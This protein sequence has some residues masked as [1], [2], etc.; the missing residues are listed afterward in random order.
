MNGPRKSKL[1][2][3]ETLAEMGKARIKRNR[4]SQI[5]W[6]DT[7]VLDQR[8]VLGDGRVY[9]PGD[10]LKVERAFKPTEP[11]MRFV[12]ELR[13]DVYVDG[14]VVAAWRY[15]TIPAPDDEPF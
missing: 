1:F 3:Q 2:D 14:Y 12:D 7:L 13:R 10:K 5:V 11:L 4:A 6:H 8:V 9:V 15:H